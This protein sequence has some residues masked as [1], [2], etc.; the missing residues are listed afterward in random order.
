MKATELLR[1]QMERTK[2]MTTVLLRDMQDAP[3][4]APTPSGGN[5]PLWVAGHVA[6]SEARI[7]SELM[8]GKP[9]PMA[10]WAELF[11]PG[12]M[13]SYDPSYY[14]IAIPDLLAKWDEIRVGTL[15]ILAGLSDEDLDKAVAHCP[16]ERVAL[17]GTYARCFSLI[18]MHPLNHRGQVA[19]ARRAL[20]RKPLFM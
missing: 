12:S 10:E 16:P 14:P 1:G 9:S 4:T 3:L 18:A 15:E 19:D 17:L 8:L 11:R 5:H 20:G 7:T 13:P 2:E 6:N